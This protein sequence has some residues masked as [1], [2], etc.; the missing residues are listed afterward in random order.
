MILNIGLN[1]A[2]IGP[3]GFRGLALSTT[4]SYSI[5]CLALI[6]VLN[7][8]NEGL[9]DRELVEGV[10]RIFGAAFFMGVVTLGV[11]RF[12]VSWWPDPTLL[13]RTGVVVLPIAASCLAY[14]I[15]SKGFQVKEYDHFLEGL[16]RRSGS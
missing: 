5:N 14:G 3:L 16:R 15:F 7:S 2:L 12:S 11:Y 13:H 9:I 4:I 10:V 6:A 8:R 1:I